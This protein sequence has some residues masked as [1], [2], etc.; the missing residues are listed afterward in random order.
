[1]KKIAFVLILAWCDLAFGQSTLVPDTVD[2]PHIVAGGDP[3]GQN[4]VTLLQVVNNNSSSTKG[5]FSLFSDNGSPLAYRHPDPIAPTTLRARWY[6]AG[7]QPVAEYL[8]RGLLPLAL[9]PG[10]IAMRQLTVPVPPSAGDYR[11]VVSSVAAPDEALSMI[12]VHTSPA[13]PP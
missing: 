9:A 8:T 1:M 2:F 4:Y 7:G 13:P 6:D 12:K 5:H 11:L 3:A 10:E